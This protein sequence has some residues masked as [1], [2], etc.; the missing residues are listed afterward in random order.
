MTKFEKLEQTFDLP[1]IEDLVED[2]DKSQV[3]DQ[4]REFETQL[5]DVDHTL[6]HDNEMDEIASLALEYGRGLHDLGMNVEVKHAGEIFSASSNMLKIAAD[7]RNSKME[8]RLKLMK[9]ELD[10]LRLERSSPE[11]ETIDATPVHTLDRNT[12]LAQIREITNSHK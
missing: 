8:K 5:T 3:L 10:R 1:S 2:T 4:A 7:A 12:L 6:L 11:P 9:L